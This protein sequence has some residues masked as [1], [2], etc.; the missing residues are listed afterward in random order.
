MGRCE[1]VREPLIDTVRA[2]A[3]AGVVAGHWLVT[4]VVVG[5]GGV[6]D[7]LAV[8]SPLRPLPEL[9]PLSWL[10]QTL[11]LFFFAGGYAGVTSHRRAMARGES[12]ARW[13]LVRLRRLVTAVAVVMLAWGVVL[14]VLGGWADLRPGAAAVV[15]N[16]VT[17]PLWFLGVY[18]LLLAGIGLARALHGRMG[19]AAVLLPIGAATLVELAVAAGVAQPVGYLT[20]PLVWW[21]PWQFGV[22]LASGWRP[23]ARHAASLAVAGVAAMAVLIGLAGYPASAVG[24]TAARSNLNPP[25]LVALSLA[26]AQVGMVLLAAPVLRRLAGWRGWRA[27]IGWI[28]ER[29]LP[30][31]LLHQSALVAVVLFGWSVG[32]LPGLHDAPAGLG[33]VAVRLVWL[34]VFGLVLLP[35]LAGLRTVAGGF[36]ARSNPR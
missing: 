34:P 12:A 20:L 14:A 4:A 30:I 26:I 35:L 13:Y 2:M 31:F 21:A 33:W 22:A 11:G 24:G 19:A 29:T 17:S 6:L 23:G 15:I 18:L 7:D 36:F 5:P 27:I 16:L 25:S 10:L 3:M 28:N 8:I 9:T 32:S 1:L